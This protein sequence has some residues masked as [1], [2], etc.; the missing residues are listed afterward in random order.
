M[1][2]CLQTPSWGSPQDTSPPRLLVPVKSLNPHLWSLSSSAEAPTPPC[3]SPWP[4]GC[5]RPQWGLLTAQRAHSATTQQLGQFGEENKHFLPVLGLAARQPASSSF[6][7]L[8][9]W[10][11]RGAG[12]SGVLRADTSPLP[13]E[14]GRRGQWRSRQA[15]LRASSP[16]ELQGRRTSGSSPPC[17]ALCFLGCSPAT[18]CILGSLFGFPLLRQWGSCWRATLTSWAQSRGVSLVFGYAWG[19]RH[20]QQAFSPGLPR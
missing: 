3:P 16:R 12:A 11:G 14:G 17:T 10:G 8:L 7:G 13:W 6:L 4:P 2:L 15:Q 9:G 5:G 1:S 19:A 18:A 20:C